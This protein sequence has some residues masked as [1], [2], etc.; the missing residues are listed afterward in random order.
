M[1][2]PKENEHPDIELPLSY[3]EMENI[4][5]GKQYTWE[6]KRNNNGKSI[7]I[8]AYLDNRGIFKEKEE[9]K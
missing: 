2:K 3:I 7:I 5:S 4:L 6:L 9:D 8:H 1:E